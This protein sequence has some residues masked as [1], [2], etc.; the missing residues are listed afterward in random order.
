M[1]TSNP[2][3]VQEQSPASPS[4]QMVEFMRR[5]ELAR[6]LGIELVDMRLGS[7]R[8]AMI[9]G[10]QH[11]NAHGIL[12]GGAVFT[13]ADFAF[14]AAGNSHGQIALALHVDINFLN[15]APVG[16]KLLAEATEEYLGNRT[17]LYHLSVTT[18]DG[19]LIAACHGM[20]Y[21]KQERFLENA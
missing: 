17:A 12:H 15:T 13:L 18:E 4:P 7:A 3:L 8:A 19:T 6:H 21:R 9:V 10:P 16:A 11:L 14:A 1:L 2:R 5:D 20:V